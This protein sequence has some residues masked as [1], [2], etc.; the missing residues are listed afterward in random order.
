MKSSVDEIRARFDADVERFSDPKGGQASTMDAALALDMIVGTIRLLHEDAGSLLDIGCGAG[1][2]SVR[3]LEAVPRLRCAILDLSR[4][5]LDRA[6]SR[7]ARAGGTVTRRIQGDVRDEELGNREHDIAVAAAVL[8]HLRSREEW[9]AVIGKIY[10]SLKDGGSF[11]LWDLV[12]HECPAVQEIQTRRHAVF[13]VEA[14]GEDYSK[15]MFD[16]IERE[17]SP[18]TATFIMEELKRSGFEAVDIVHK[19]SCFAAIM[20]VKGGRR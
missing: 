14:G 18:E 20:A 13:L 17:D 12:R 3:I 8:H 19:N 11:W 7:I 6:A 15:T 9:R 4:P 5:M 2:F 16:N 10:S 1:N